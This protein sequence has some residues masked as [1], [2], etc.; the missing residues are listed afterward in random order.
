MIFLVQF[1]RA[2]KGSDGNNKEAEERKRAMKDSF[3]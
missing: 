3:G 1:I 2:G